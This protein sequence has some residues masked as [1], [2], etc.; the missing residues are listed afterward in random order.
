VGIKKPSALSKLNF[1]LSKAPVFFIL[2]ELRKNPD[3]QK[4]MNL[5]LKIRKTDK[6]TAKTAYC[7]FQKSMADTVLT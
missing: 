2:T 6:Q 7:L 3:S 5:F 1:G 4:M